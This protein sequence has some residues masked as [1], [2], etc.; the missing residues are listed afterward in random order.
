M[1]EVIEK[2]AREA[3]KLLMEYFKK[4]VNVSYKGAHNDLLTEA[5]TA[6]QTKIQ[7][8]ITDELIKK[9]ID[10][11]E[12]GFL[13]EE[14]LLTQGKYTFIIDPLD[15]TV[16]FASGFKY[17]CIPIAL[18]IANRITAGV[19]YNPSENILYLAEKGKGAYKIIDNKE[20]PLKVVRKELKNSLISFLLSKNATVVNRQLEF[21]SKIYPMVRGLRSTHATALDI[22]L[23]AENVFQISHHSGC[24]IWDLAAAELI[25]QEAGGVVLDK[26][27]DEI[28]Y[29]L[30]DPNKKYF[31]M[32]GSAEI[33]AEILKY[34]K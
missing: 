31:Y 25:L 15:G 10:K 19:V 3:G 28:Q 33:V 30:T 22:C 8:V 1:I 21:I 20:I 2:A 34:V 12:I 32:A 5:D 23:C 17:F 13:G 18:F 27:G 4:G 11:S 24:S 26:N 9:G 6:S 16:N 7:Q 29:D 14:N